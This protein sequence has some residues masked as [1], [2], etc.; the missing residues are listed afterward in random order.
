MDTIKQVHTDLYGRQS[1]A[2]RLFI[3]ILLAVLVSFLGWIAETVLFYINRGEFVDR[4]LLTLPFCPM[5]G[6]SALSIYALLRTPCSGIWIKLTSSPKTRT[7]RFAAMLAC[8]LL[9]A[10]AAAL[11][12]SLVE[13]GTGFFYENRFGLHLWNYHNDEN[14]IHGFVCL[15]YSLM[16]GALSLA[17]MGLVWY[18]LQNL[19]A[20]AKTAVLATAALGFAGVITADFVLNMVYLFIHGTRF[21][22]W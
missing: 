6:L 11:L 16:W 21:M 14:N 5:Y 19:L 3:L 2:K 13:Y 1:G 7:G 9:Y 12:A 15:Q 22:P 10:A 17:V 4:G 8:L 18:P 20:R